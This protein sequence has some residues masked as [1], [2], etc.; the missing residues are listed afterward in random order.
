MTSTAMDDLIRRCADV[1]QPHRRW[2]TD[3]DDD[4]LG[5]HITPDPDQG[6]HTVHASPTTSL[7]TQINDCLRR[8][9]GISV[10]P[11]HQPVPEIDGY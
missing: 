5:E 8:A 11:G 7:G 10:R 4:D 9:V 2:E 6:Q 3:T 1:S